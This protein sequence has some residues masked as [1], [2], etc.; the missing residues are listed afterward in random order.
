MRHHWPHSIELAW[1]RQAPMR[2]P[3]CWTS[4]FGNSKP[5]TDGAHLGPHGLLD[6]PV[7]P[8]RGH[9]LGVVVQKDQEVAFHGG[10]GQVELA[11]VVELV[12]VA[13]HPPGQGGQV[14]EGLRV[15]ALV[16]HHHQ[17]EVVVDA[18]GATTLSMQR[19]S[20]WR[21]LR[22]GMMMLTLGSP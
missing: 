17:L 12:R 15:V 9:D 8:V 18:C 6:Q 13:Q 19:P 7:E 2:M 14:L 16:V 3:S 10:G 20:R 21:P 5:G 22:V 4:P 1:P 11:G